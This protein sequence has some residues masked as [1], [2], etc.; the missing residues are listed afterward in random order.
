MSRLRKRESD[1]DRIARL[2][3]EWIMAG[4]LSSERRGEY[5]DFFNSLLPEPRCPHIWMTF[6]DGRPPQRLLDWYLTWFAE[7][8]A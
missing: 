5:V 6:S 1:A 3:N 4:R 8:Q 7:C 2:V